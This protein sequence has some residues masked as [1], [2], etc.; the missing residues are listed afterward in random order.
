MATITYRTENTENIIAT[1]SCT[2]LTGAASEHIFARICTAKIYADLYAPILVTF[3]MIRGYMPQVPQ[4][5]VC[6]MDEARKLVEAIGEL[7]AERY[8]ANIAR[9]AAQIE[10]DRIAA[11]AAYGLPA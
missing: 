7:Y 1:V 6:D 2:N 3:A 11:R 10:T 5:F 8:A 4:V 9:L